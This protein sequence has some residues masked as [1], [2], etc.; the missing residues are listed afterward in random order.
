MSGKIGTIKPGIYHNMRFADYLAE[1]A[2]SASR[3]KLFYKSA[4]D[5]KKGLLET[6][7]MKHGTHEHL[8]VLEYDRYKEEILVMP[9]KRTKE[10]GTE[11]NFTRRGQYWDAYVKE[12][13]GR[14]IV[15]QKENDQYMNVAAAIRENPKAV[16]ILDGGEHEVSLFW[17]D[18]VFGP[19]KARCD[20]LGDTYIADLKR[21]AS[22]LSKFGFTCDKFGYDIQ[23]YFYLLGAAAVGLHKVESFIFVAYESAWPHDSTCQEAYQGMLESGEDKIEVAADHLKAAAADKNGFH[24]KFP[25]LVGV[26]FPIDTEEW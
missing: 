8:S 12:N 18:P 16:E 21:T 4:R 24:G 20:C 23:A 22:D 13:K 19:S 9:A 14:I 1:P 15:N 2:M 17:N 10:N 3:L 7:S 5:G 6:E 25:D 26:D 11:V